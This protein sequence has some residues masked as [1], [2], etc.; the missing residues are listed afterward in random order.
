MVTSAAPRM[1]A[2]WIEPTGKRRGGKVLIICSCHGLRMFGLQCVRNERKNISGRFITDEHVKMHSEPLRFFSVSGKNLSETP[3][4]THWIIIIICFS[5]RAQSLVRR[6]SCETDG[7]WLVLCIASLEKYFVK[8][9]RMLVLQMHWQRRI[10]SCSSWLSAFQHTIFITE[11][12]L[13]FYFSRQRLPDRK[14][15]RQQIHLALS[16]SLWKASYASAFHA[17]FETWALVT[18]GRLVSFIQWLNDGRNVHFTKLK[19]IRT[20]EFA[21]ISRVRME[22]FAPSATHIWTAA[23]G[24]WP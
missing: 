20:F 23:D 14:I 17:W 7:N 16:T 21:L 8:T 13:Q 24:G 15:S 12:T 1:Y 18:E 9:F 19:F 22:K 6:R 10:L 5:I 3:K 2:G 4:T 11:T